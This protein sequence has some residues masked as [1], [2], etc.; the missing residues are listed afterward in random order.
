MPIPLTSSD[1]RAIFPRALQSVI[2]AFAAKQNSSSSESTRGSPRS[3]R[4]GRRMLS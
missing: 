3:L 4:L 1:L 2:D